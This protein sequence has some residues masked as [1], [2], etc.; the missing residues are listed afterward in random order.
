MVNNESLWDHG[1]IMY[2]C[3]ALCDF[4]RGGVEYHAG[5][6]MQFDRLAAELQEQYGHVRVLSAVKIK[7][8]GRQTKC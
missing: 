1:K 5:D 6:T 4:W 2:Q 7:P 3:E 8:R